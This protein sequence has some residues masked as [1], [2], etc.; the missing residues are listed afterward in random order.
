M[1]YC[2]NFEI[3]GDVEENPTGLAAYDF[4]LYLLKKLKKR[5]DTVLLRAP[6]DDAESIEEG[7][8]FGKAV[9]T[10][11]GEERVF[12]IE[13]AASFCEHLEHHYLDSRGGMKHKVL[14][15]CAGD[16]ILYSSENYGRLLQVERLT[17]TETEILSDNADLYPEVCGYSCFNFNAPEPEDVQPLNEE[18]M[19]GLIDAIEKDIL[20]GGFQ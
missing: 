13:D 2:M 6:R 17:R 14:V 5:C 11:C 16:K 3:L 4:W 20:E 19:Q 12:E 8:R 10:E 9:E 1:A 7:E 18:E 15:F